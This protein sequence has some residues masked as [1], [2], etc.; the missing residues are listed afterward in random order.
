[1]LLV[2]M[3]SLSNCWV[4]IPQF[5]ALLRLY[6]KADS[7][8]V[9]H[10]AQRKHFPFDLKDK[11]AFAKWKSLLGSFLGKTIFAVGFEVHALQFKHPNV[12]REG[13]RLC[14]LCAAFP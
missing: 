8:K 2:Q 4:T 12:I 11:H 6:L 3:I 13:Y 10:S 5:N 7:L 1:M 14:V 9:F